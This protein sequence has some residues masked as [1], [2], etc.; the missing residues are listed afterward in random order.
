MRSE[1]QDLTRCIVSSFCRHH[2]TTKD[3]SGYH[4]GGLSAG[5]FEP[6]DGE[7]FEGISMLY[8]IGK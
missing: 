2:P 3:H 1:T 5:I 8:S 4:E 7:T 6:A